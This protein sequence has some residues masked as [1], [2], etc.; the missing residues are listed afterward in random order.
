M[1]F[2]TH[3]PGVPSGVN[4]GGGSSS[5][6]ESD[7]VMRFATAV[8]SS[9][10]ERTGA[11]Q[12]S[13]AGIAGLDFTIGEEPS[14]VLDD[15]IE[16]EVTDNAEQYSAPGI[17]GRPLPPRTVDGDELHMDVVCVQTVEG[18]VPIAYRDLRLAMAGDA[19]PGEG[20]LAFVGYGGGFHSM[21]PVE[22]GADPAGGGT[23]HVIYCPYAFDG[24]G[25]A[26]K[27]HSI[28]LDPTPG[29]ESIMI[30][31]ANGLAIT[32]S[33]EDK[34]ALLLKN[35]SGDATLRLDDDGVTI[36]AVQIVLSGGVIVGEPVFAVP[37]LAGPA[38]PPSTKF[39]VSP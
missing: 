37:L 12:Y 19:A 13:I 26:Q 28:I 8:S 5:S 10:S 4:V 6:T 30:A 25:V 32:M 31:H 33:N 2:G 29:N 16:A 21:T 34:K 17:I 11:V 18:I 14:I 9:L 36:T 24:D 7:F 1:R 35:A 20:V 23:I 22:S 27:A 3:S 15:D 39:Y 38:S